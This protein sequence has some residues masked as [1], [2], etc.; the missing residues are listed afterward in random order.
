MD[1]PTQ[2]LITINIIK[3]DFR[4]QKINLLI[5]TKCIYIYINLRRSR[6]RLLLWLFWWMNVC[7]C[8]CVCACVRACVRVS[9]P[10]L[11]QFALGSCYAVHI[12]RIVNVMKVYIEWN[13]MQV[14]LIRFCKT[15][16]DFTILRSEEFS[17]RRICVIDRWRCVTDGS[18]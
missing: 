4:Y 1:K 12:K 10:R 18:A 13:N 14:E 2:V 8:V 7:V 16:I 11:I 5:L 17:D 9:D 6:D 15:Y 3:N